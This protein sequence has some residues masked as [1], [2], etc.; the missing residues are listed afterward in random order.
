MDAVER[1]TGYAEQVAAVLGNTSTG[2][3]VLA[4]LGRDGAPLSDAEMGL[5]KLNDFVFLGA[6]GRFEEG[7]IDAAAEPGVDS[8]AIM[9]HAVVAFIGLVS[10]AS[11]PKDDGSDWADY[12]RRLWTLPDER[13][14]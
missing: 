1:L 11:V 10:S 9:A 3:F 14:N 12:M 13:P 2:E 4:D 7:R 6:V 8:A 5:A